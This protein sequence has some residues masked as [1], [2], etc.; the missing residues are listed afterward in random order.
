MIPSVTKLGG[1][2]P[3]PFNPATNISYAVSNTGQVTIDIY[4]VKGE[5]VKTL[6]NREVAAGNHSVTWMGE[7]N[8]G[9][10]VTSGIYFYKMRAGAKYTSSRKMILLK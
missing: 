8:S 1:N 5:L 4:N 2:H 6:V 9:K 7:D 10:S 3:N